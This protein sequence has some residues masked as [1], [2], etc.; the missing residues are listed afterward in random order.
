[1]QAAEVVEEVELEVEG[2]E[3]VV[4]DA[5]G[6]TA[7]DQTPPECDVDEMDGA[8]KPQLGTGEEDLD[9]D[10]PAPAGGSG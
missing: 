6:A 4:D 1:M 5:S 3:A 10:S 2:S 7:A 9:G 8:E